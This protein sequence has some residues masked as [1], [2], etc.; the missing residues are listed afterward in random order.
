MDIRPDKTAHSPIIERPRR[1]AYL[2]ILG[3]CVYMGVVWYFGWTDIRDELLNADLPLVI[4]SAVMILIATWARVGKWRYALGSGH[5]AIGL[6]FVS[7]A[8]GNWT[9]GRLGEFAPM[10]IRAHR[11]PK[12]GAWIM[13]DRLLEIAVTLALGLYGL[14]V[15]QLLTPVQFGIVLSA[16]VL[17]CFVGAYLITRRSFFLKLAERSRPESFLYKL[18]MLFAAASEE[19]YFFLRKLPGVAAITVVTKCMDLFAVA[20]LFQAIGYRPGFALMSAAKCALAIVSF[21]PI[22]PSATGVPHGTQAWI[23]NTV[24]DIPYEAL[25]AGIGLEVVVVSVTF[26]SSFGAAS[27]RLRAMA[28]SS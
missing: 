11:T 17:L 16:T 3:L 18:A 4:A 15:I 19:F 12:I 1:A 10:A 14:A 13:F 21:I 22:T 25:V 20:L 26:W 23:M 27:G 6:F 7:K 8:T 24:A 5:N 2:F 9:P 28:Q